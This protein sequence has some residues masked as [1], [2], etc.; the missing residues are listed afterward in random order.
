MVSEIQPISSPDNKEHPSSEQLSVPV[1]TGPKSTVT[2]RT[3]AAP[4]GK[5]FEDEARGTVFWEVAES[6]SEDE[7]SAEQ[8]GREDTAWSNPFQIEWIKWY[9]GIL[10]QS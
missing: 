9:T 5:I 8:M 7:D 3:N 6:S 1:L 2:P 10:F 4:R